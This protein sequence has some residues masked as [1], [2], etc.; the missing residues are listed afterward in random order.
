MATARHCLIQAGQQIK[1]GVLNGKGHLRLI[2]GFT[3]FNSGVGD[4]VDIALVK[5]QPE[6]I[7]ILLEGYKFL[8]FSKVRPTT[9][10]DHETDYL[11][12]GHTISKTNIDNKKRKIKLKP[13]VHIGKSLDEKAYEKKGYEKAINTLI[14]YDQRRG[15]IIGSNEMSMSPTPKGI[16][17]CGLWYI[18][19]YTIANPQDADFYLM[20]IMI[21]HDKQNRMMVGTKSEE[22]AKIF[23][24]SVNKFGNL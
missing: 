13:L 12:V 8:D 4:K 20:G 16:S 22:L 15:T 5:L 1:V 10:I 18:Q 6:S 14:S 23:Q 2:S 3:V 21:E 19:S 9:N 17:G 11:I 24:L 7:Q